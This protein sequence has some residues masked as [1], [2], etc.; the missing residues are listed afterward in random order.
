M[1]TFSISI[2]HLP[3]VS[4]YYYNPTRAKD[5]K[6]ISAKQDSNQERAT[7]LT[8]KRAAMAPSICELWQVWCSGTFFDGWSNQKV[9]PKWTQLLS[10]TSKD[11]QKKIISNH[12]VWS[13]RKSWQSI[14]VLHRMCPISS[15]HFSANKTHVP[16]RR[17]R[18]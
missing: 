3:T 15:Q 6:R 9:D 2:L 11:Y 16:V 13:N 17:R 12:V 7:K 5:L 10:L 1:V 8:P 4:N 18:Q 14:A